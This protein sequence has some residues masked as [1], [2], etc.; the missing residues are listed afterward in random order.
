MTKFQGDPP[1]QSEDGTFPQL[2]GV[3]TVENA[4]YYLS[5]IERFIQFRNDE[6]YLDV[7]LARAELRYIQ[8]MKTLDD[9]E[10]NLADVPP[11]LG[12]PVLRPLKV[13][14]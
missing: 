14:D 10:G 2:G 9:S 12:E 6:K 3:V 11:P 5:L 13:D 7:A 1:T 4:F 8:Y